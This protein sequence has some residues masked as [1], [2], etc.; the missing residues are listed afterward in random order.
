MG[1]K[2]RGMGEGIESTTRMFPRWFHP[3]LRFFAGR[4]DRL[5]FDANLLVALIAPRACLMQ[6]ALNDEVSNTWGSE[7]TYHSALRAYQLLGRPEALGILRLPGFHGAN[8]TGRPFTGD[9]AGLLLY[10]TLHRYGFASRP[11]SLAADDGL[12]L[13]DLRITNSVKCVPPENKPLPAEIRQCNHYLAAE[14]A[15]MP[16]GSVFIALGSVGHNAALQALGI[17]A[18]TY[19]FAHGAE[20]VLPDGRTLIDSYHCSR[21]NTQTRRLTDEMFEAIFARAAELIGRER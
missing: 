12:R 21:Y 4:E 3:R 17:K 19:K 6:Y 13:I 7:Q 11:E 18:T 15:A 8:A 9:H 14:L 5:P 16:P 10:R 2:R 20:H 1:L